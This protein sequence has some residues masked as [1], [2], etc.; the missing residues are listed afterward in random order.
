MESQVSLLCDTDVKRRRKVCQ[1]A[2]N[3]VSLIEAKK[4]GKHSPTFDPK[5][6]LFTVTCNDNWNR[7]KISQY[8]DVY[9]TVR[10]CDRR[11]IKKPTRCQLLYLLYFLDTQHVSGINMSIFRSLRLCC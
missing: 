2:A 8:S 7:N 5:L 3:R 10:H 9:W 4:F 6:Y 11:R 1:K